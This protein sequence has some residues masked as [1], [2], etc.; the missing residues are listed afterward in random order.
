MHRIGW[1]LLLGGA[2][3]YLAMTPVMR[4]YVLH[5]FGL[6]WAFLLGIL[7]LLVREAE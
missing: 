2:V 7:A 4:R 6:I 1:L 5:V 3:A